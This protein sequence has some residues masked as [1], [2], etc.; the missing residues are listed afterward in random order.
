MILWKRLTYWDK[1]RNQWFPG[2]GGGGEW[3]TTK[4][5]HEGTSG[6]MKLL[7]MTL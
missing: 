2:I 6:V 3:L 5:Q 7:C 4:E 1:K